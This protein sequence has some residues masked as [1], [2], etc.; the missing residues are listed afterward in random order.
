[1]RMQAI[2]MVAQQQ[3]MSVL[4]KRGKLVALFNP[5]VSHQ[6]E[7]NAALT[8]NLTV[9]EAQKQV[10]ML[11]RLTITKPQ[12]CIVED[13]TKEDSKVFIIHT[14][15]TLNMANNDNHLKM[16]L[17][18]QGT[19]IFKTAMNIRSTIGAVEIMEPFDTSIEMKSDPHNFDIVVDIKP[20]RVIFSYND[21]KI[22]M[23]A[24]QQWAVM[25]DVTA[26][27]EDTTSLGYDTTDETSKL[28]SEDGPSSITLNSSTAIDEGSDV[29][30][31]S[32]Q[33]EDPTPSDVGP[34]S[35]DSTTTGT[36]SEHANNSNIAPSTPRQSSQPTIQIDS[37][38]KDEL[39]D[40]PLS[41]PGSLTKKKDKKEEKK[42]KAKEKSKQKK[43]R[44]KE[45]KEKK[46]REKEKKEHEK[47]QKHR[48]S[49]EIKSQPASAQNTPVK[50]DKEPDLQ[51]PSSEKL[52]KQTSTSSLTSV[53]NEEPLSR[54]G[55]L[56]KLE[57]PQVPS[58][59]QKIVIS[60]HSFEILFIDDVKGIDVPLFRIFVTKWFGHVLDWS[61]QLQLA[62]ALQM[63]I[64]YFNS[65]LDTWEP[66]VE[67][68][69]VELR[70][71][72]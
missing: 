9:S 19:E 33:W 18:L 15:L 66:F 21:V 12:F 25:R 14:N 36:G 26:T 28:G 4:E 60:P 72:N 51:P 55:S 63:H 20:F 31:E 70:V 42:E 56:P 64:V 48:R 52:S 68:W 67:P 57:F 44:E 35:E 1:M 46:E 50:K 34:L 39:K 29:S 24:A 7:I 49:S 58:K 65:D 61:A 6:A 27:V 53:T 40:E 10:G 8:K 17:T 47:K 22:L 3:L 43:E 5:E 16:S 69:E 54:S 11:M 30:D 62:V 41:A 45:K 23:N 13:L 2:I 71:R 37:P 38:S 32:D 59:T